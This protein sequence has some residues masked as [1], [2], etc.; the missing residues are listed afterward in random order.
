[1]A[2]AVDQGGV[3]GR[4]AGSDNQN[5]ISNLPLLFANGYPISLEKISES[6]LEKFIPFMVLC[7]MG[8]VHKTSVNSE[9]EWWPD[10]IPFSIPLHKPKNFEGVS[11]DRQH[12][13]LGK[14]NCER[15][16]PCLK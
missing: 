11:F 5:M 1:M 16:A 14:Q 8:N 4:N 9:P 12:H 2:A 3:A 13:I 7:S 10:D 6:Q 15:K